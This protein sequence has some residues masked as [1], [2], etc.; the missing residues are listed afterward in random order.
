MV[1]ESGQREIEGERETER[2]MKSE[3]G[4]EKDAEIGRQCERE[5][6]ERKRYC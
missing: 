6:E 2:G 3:G 4:T 1:V 5:K